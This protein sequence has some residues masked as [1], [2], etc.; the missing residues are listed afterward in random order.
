MSNETAERLM[1]GILEGWNTKDWNTLEKY[2]VQDWID[3]TSPPGMNDLNALHGIFN[4]FTA[5]FPDLE[6]DIP[7][8]I[9][10]GS[11]VA[12]LYTISGT[13]TG[14][15]MGIPASGKEINIKGMTMLA[16]ED[17]KCAQAWGVMDLL[18]LMQQIGAVPA[19]GG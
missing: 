2:H 11:S 1:D 8:A 15:F 19:P 5:A 16:M 13:H 17:G 4:L 9:V 14:E 12:Y 7:R 18:S 3:H 10:D 6:L